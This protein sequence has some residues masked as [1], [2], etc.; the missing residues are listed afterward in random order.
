MP[1]T[2]ATIGLRTK[3]AKAIAVALSG[4]T[5][6]EFVQR[7]NLELYDRDVPETGQPHHEVMELPWAEAQVAVRRYEERIENVTTE[8]LR[9][10]LEELRSRAV[11]VRAI[12]IVGSPDRSLEKIGNHHIRAHAAEGILFRRAVEI[13]ATR[14]KLRWWHFSD[15]GF[16]DLAVNELERTSREVKTVMRAIGRSAG[17]PWRADERAAA[18]AAWIVA[19][20]RSA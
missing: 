1:K 2:T 6:P 19:A 10:L 11:D 17:R 5:A 3:T 14:C 9:S 15:R 12:G 13:A 18:T 4:R 8:R 16:E 20:G 7:W